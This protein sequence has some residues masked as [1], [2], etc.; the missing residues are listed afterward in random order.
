MLEELQKKLDCDERIKEITSQL[1]EKSVEIK[2]LQAELYR[3]EERI[4]HWK[5]KVAR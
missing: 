2:Q 3:T 5:R 1:E 4:R